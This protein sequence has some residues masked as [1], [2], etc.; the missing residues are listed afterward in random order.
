M[1]GPLLLQQPTLSRT[2]IVFVYAGNLWSVP[3]SGG[4]A[5]R[6]TTG[7]AQKT[8]P[9]FSPDGRWIA[10]TADTNGNHNV[11]VMPAAGGDPRQLTFHSGPDDVAGWTP[12]GKQVLFTSPRDAYSHEVVQLF[13]VP[14]AGGFPERLPFPLGFGGSY[15]PDGERI[16]YVPVAFP[17][18]TWKDYHGGTMPVIWIANLADSSVV[19]MPHADSI[20]FNPMWLG[21]RIYFLSNRDGRFTL[22]DYDLKTQ[23]VTDL[24]PNRSDFDLKSAS[25]GPGAIVYEQ[26]GSLHLYD[27][28][29]G[30][31]HPVNVSI[32]GDFPDARAHFEKVARH[33]LN[34]NISPT[35]AR[36]VFEAH[37]EILTAPGEKGSIRNLTNSPAVADRD[38]AWSP[39]GRSIAYFSDASG[40]YR[41]RISDQTGLQPVKELALGDPPA[42]YYSPIWSPDSRKIAYTDN[43]LNVWYL[44]VETGRNLKVDTNTYENPDREL[45]PAW[46]PDSQWLAYTKQLANHLRAVF[47]YSLA[48][49]KTTQITDGM[50]DAQSAAFDRSGKYLFFAASTNAGPTTGWLDMSSF[51]HPVTRDVYVAVLRK[52]LPSPLAPE[53]DDEKAGGVAAASPSGEAASK[54]GEKPAPPPEV[55]I[56]FESIS[57]RILALPI[58][59]ANYV[60][61][62]A[63]KPGQIFLVQGPQEGL[64]LA[65]GEPPAL[66]VVKFDL[67]TRKTETLIGGLRA[68]ALSYNGEKF[69]Y[70]QGMNWG[71][72]STATPFKP[73]TGILHLD[74][75]NVW[76]VPQEEWKQMYREVWRIERD[77]F[78]DKNLHGL[79]LA[80]TEAQ[81][82]RFLPGIESRGDLNYLFNQMLGQINVG[83]MFVRGGDMP[84]V[85]RVS[86]G[87]LGT[88]Y[89]IDHNRYRF[90]RVYSGENW[91]PQLHAPLTQPGVN[92]Q[93]GEYLLAVNGRELH[94]SDNIYSFFLDTVGKQ[95]ALEVGPNPDGAGSRQVTV[96]PVASEAGLRNRAWIDD[97]IRTVDRLSGGRVA[98]V[99]LPDTA[100]GGYTNFN[101]YF[102]AQVGKQAAVIDERFNTGGTAAD[103]IIEYLQRKL[104]NYWYTR[105]GRIFTTP[106]DAIFG[107]KAM[108]INQFSGSGGDA[109]PW[110]FHHVGL[111]PLVGERTWGG[112]VGIYDYPPLIDGGSVTAPR[113]AF[114]NTQGQWDVENHG[115]PPD[116][117]VALDPRAWRQ[118][119]DNQLERAVQLVMAALEKN[120]PPKPRVPPFPNYGKLP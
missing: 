43:R 7:P 69:L 113:V 74:D 79:D 65:S 71:I 66:T 3:R 44:D 21:D 106:E 103:Y 83:H 26:F 18:G 16:A 40:E 45:H 100:G 89:A 8:D 93:P 67:A 117:P 27:L 92:V 110:Y 58:P 96:V 73:G 102:F 112:L 99:Y 59:A 84:E 90:A 95:V 105:Y 109:L 91:N 14:V 85:P 114:F 11:Y 20:D 48:S 104:W 53:S 56:D 46:S 29:S 41:V 39:D 25:L 61:L 62:E 6:L 19:K 75:M 47:V 50:S 33:I 36:A 60:D 81:Y 80:A 118:G 70:R 116:V 78:Y 42:F 101:R 51:P 120:P 34:A 22:F 17:W 94:A 86:V 5:V 107:P 15:S 35:G 32:T 49:G 37:G 54:P 30:R 76:V 97:N 115:T 82:A 23:K 77:F 87:L 108:I 12:D 4:E 68:F 57:Q 111:G 9:Q 88:D 64:L 31:E 63:G 98:Y 2:A 38:P 119:H 10:F 1:T 52:D 55:R 24:V 72:A 13:T 28:K